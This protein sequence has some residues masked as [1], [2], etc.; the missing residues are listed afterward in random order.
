MTVK[1]VIA[2]VK[3]PYYY[4]GSSVGYVT[5]AA[6]DDI[7]E[8]LKNTSEE[9]RGKFT[10]TYNAYEEFIRT[11][12]QRQKYH[13]DNIT[14]MSAERDMCLAMV[15]KSCEGENYKKRA[16]LLSERI[17]FSE[18]ALS[19][20]EK[21]Y[22]E[23]TGRKDVFKR[24]LDNWKDFE[25]RKVREVRNTQMAGKYSGLI[26]ICEGSECGNYWFY[27]DKSIGNQGGTSY[28]RVGK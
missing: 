14:K 11:F 6:A 20:N 3:A 9:Y 15:D 24:Y 19:N 12:P 2:K 25:N 21:K 17:A 26:I 28:L 18:N 13:R 5:I 4:I 22:A 1:E 23:W 27:G 7:L 10:K 8:E 16:K